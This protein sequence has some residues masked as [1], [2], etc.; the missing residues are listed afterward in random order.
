MFRKSSP[1]KIRALQNPVLTLTACLSE[2]DEK[3]VGF[4]VR[5]IMVVGEIN[6][7]VNYAVVPTS[8]HPIS[9]CLIA[10]GLF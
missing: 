1:L 8:K 2:T 7:T 6:L 3:K 4:Q 5:D 9:D 10:R